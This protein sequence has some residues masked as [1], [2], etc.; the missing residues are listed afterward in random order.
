[1]FAKPARPGR[2]KTRMRPLLTAPESA[3]LHL[4]CVQDTA[5]RV[6]SVGGYRKW[7]LVAGSFP[8]AQKLAR[9]AGLSSRW[10]L[11]IQ[12]GRH[13]GER[14]AFAFNSHFTAGVERV[15]V[16]GTDTPWMPPQRIVEA[17]ALLDRADVVLGPTGDGGYYL[18]GARRL[19]PEMFRGIRWGTSQVLAQ[20]KAALRKAGA[21]FRLLPRDFDLDRPAD[22]RRLAGL[23]RRGA[24]R[25]PALK[26]WISNWEL[27]RPER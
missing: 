7:L 12:V 5:R 9:A 13:L 22:L 16:V 20:T 4:A 26:Q 1:V 3:A 27:A 2:V 17:F 23:L 11:G 6:G 19:V 24:I 21:S 8:E 10:C 14:L 25:A 15:V 18:V